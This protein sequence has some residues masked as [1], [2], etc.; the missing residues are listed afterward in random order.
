MIVALCTTAV[1]LALVIAA[2]AAGATHNAIPLG[3]SALSVGRAERPGSG[4]SAVRAPCTSPGIRYCDRDQNL[5]VLLRAAPILD[6]HD[7]GLDFK[8]RLNRN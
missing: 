8:T 3:V 6:S 7:R 1:I 5:G 4:T 2:W